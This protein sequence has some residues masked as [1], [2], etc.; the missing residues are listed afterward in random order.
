[1]IPLGQDPTSYQL[2]FIQTKPPSPLHFSAFTP[3]AAA[4]SCS[5]AF[6]ASA[7]LSSTHS[8]RDGHKQLD[9]MNTRRGVRLSCPTA[10]GEPPVSSEHEEPSQGAASP[11]QEN[12]SC[13]AA[14]AAAHQSAKVCKAV[15]SASAAHLGCA[16]LHKNIP[17]LLLLL[18]FP[19]TW[20]TA[21][22][23]EPFS[24]RRSGFLKSHF[25]MGWG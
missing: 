13:S 21:S 11:C 8:K 1:M 17:S 18:C 15:E 4:R 7:S 10:R 22:H 16:H 20:G 5:A 2:V 12:K 19:P 23:S 25:L 14:T 6:T 9:P 3:L 24:E